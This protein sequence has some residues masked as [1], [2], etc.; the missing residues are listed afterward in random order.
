ML[1]EFQHTIACREHTLPRDDKSSQP[2]GWIRGNTRIGPILC[3]G[4]VSCTSYSRTF[5][6]TQMA[7]ANCVHPQR[8]QLEQP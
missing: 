2:K 5:Y 4:N 7:T 6:D 8:V 3:K 1:S